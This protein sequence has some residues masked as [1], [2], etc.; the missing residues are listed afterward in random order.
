MSSQVELEMAELQL[1]SEIWRKNLPED[2]QVGSG[3]FFECGGESLG[4]TMLLIEVKEAFGV[5]VPLEA[6]FDAPSLAA[7]ARTIANLGAGSRA[8]VDG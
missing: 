1:L 6:F 7:L 3:D 8:P 5:E 4:A 2:A